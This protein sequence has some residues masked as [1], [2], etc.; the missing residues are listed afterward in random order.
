[1]HLPLIV[2][3]SSTDSMLQSYSN[4]I[5]ARFRNPMMTLQDLEVMIQESQECADKEPRSRM[6]G[7]GEP[8]ASVKPA[9]MH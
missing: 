6:G 1:M 7:L 3:V 8:T 9:P 5:R 4:E 2:N